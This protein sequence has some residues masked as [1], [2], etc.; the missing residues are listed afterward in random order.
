MIQN[1]VLNSN[2]RPPVLIKLF[3]QFMFRA[4]DADTTLEVRGVFLDLS[5]ASDK[6]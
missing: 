2:F 1:N 4:F 3:Q 6:V 5:N